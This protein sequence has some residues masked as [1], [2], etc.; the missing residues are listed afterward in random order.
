MY[1]FAGFF[2]MQQNIYLVACVWEKKKKP[3]HFCAGLILK[4]FF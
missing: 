1:A 4:K 2:A 3:A